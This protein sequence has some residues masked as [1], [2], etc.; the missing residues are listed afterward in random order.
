M[1]SLSTCPSL[2]VFLVFNRSSSFR[3][4]YAM[5]GGQIWTT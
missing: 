2:P 5:G 1:T 4:V 3:T